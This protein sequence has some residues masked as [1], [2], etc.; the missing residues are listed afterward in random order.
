MPDNPLVETFRSFERELS[1][2]AFAGVPLGGALSEALHRYLFIYSSAGGHSPP[3]FSPWLDRVR[4]ARHMTRPRQWRGDPAP[5]PTGRILVTWFASTPRYNDLIRP[6]LAHLEPGS[7]AVVHEQPAVSSQLGSGVPSV[8][9]ERIVSYDVKAWRTE[10][11]RCRP[12]WDARLAE[13][14][15][16]V[17]L[18]G[19]AREFLSLS[20]MVASQRVFACLGFLE[21][22]RP[23]AVLT[24][25]DRN[26]LWS[27]LV[28]A[29]RHLAIPT[30]TLVHGVMDKDALAFSPVIA[31]SI[32][33][34]GEMD[35]AKLRNAGEPDTKIVTAGCPRLTRELS[36]TREEGRRRLRLEADAKV[37]MYVST[38]E[39]QSPELVELFCAAIDRTDGVVGIVRLHPSERPRAF[40]SSV[41]RHPSLRFSENAQSTVDEA[42]AAADIVVTAGSGMGSDA[43]V[44]RRPVIVLNPGTVY[45]G[46]DLDLVERGG[47]P[48]AKNPEQLA[49]V[50]ESMLHDEGMR[51]EKTVA[52]E[53]YASEFCSA[54]GEDSA[55]RI[56]SF[57]KQI[58]R[59]A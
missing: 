58:A 17:E 12:H 44:K 52:A 34:W 29:A 26:H 40:A 25:Y 38:P 3:P 19:G 27:C 24:E 7:Y 13:L 53:H 10:Y 6:I 9:W 42:L 54:Y 21:R 8:Q 18:V 47:C 20:L 36:A 11:D 48:H 45:R 16:E 1:W 33:C 41:R 56:A 31:D 23:S 32:L 2:P 14:C 15:R 28:L 50:V 5:L 43:L 46:A 51:A 30:A 22:T 49:S 4:H 37:V 57:I 35:R 55:H 59:G 39:P